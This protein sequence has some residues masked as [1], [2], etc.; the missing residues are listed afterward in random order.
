MNTSFLL[1]NNLLP[2]R[3]AEDTESVPEFV[4]VDPQSTALRDAL[5]LVFGEV[6]R[7]SFGLESKLLPQLSAWYVQDPEAEDD[8]VADQFG[9]IE[10]H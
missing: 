6:P 9:S 3:G 8:T 1:V 4:S 5:R 7:I 2:V 10:L